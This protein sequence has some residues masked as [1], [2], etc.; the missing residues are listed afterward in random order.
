MEYIKEFKYIKTNNKLFNQTYNFLDIMNNYLNI[1]NYYLYLNSL[2]ER[3]INNLY[4][5]ISIK[6]HRY[7]KNDILIKEKKYID[8]NLFND[9]INNF[10]LNKDDINN[11]CKAIF[12]MN[13]IA[14]Y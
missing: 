14:I 13:S 9:I 6:W 2:S 12:I 7:V 1:N 5:I 8:H 11:Y 3:Q 10:I 4:K